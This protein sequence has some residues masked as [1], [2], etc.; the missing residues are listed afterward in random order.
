MV[1]TYAH[2]RA[3]LATDVEEGQQTVLYLLEFLGILL[4]SVLQLLELT[5]GIHIVAGVY[6]HLLAITCR[7][8]GHVGVEVDVGNQRH[9]ATCPAH[10]L[11]DKVHVLRL[12]CA[13]GG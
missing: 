3:V 9:W 2:R 12:A 13:L 6:A 11:A 7:H 1:H 8:V 4:V 5:G 10:R